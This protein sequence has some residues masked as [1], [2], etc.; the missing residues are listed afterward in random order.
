[1]GDFNSLLNPSL[2]KFHDSPLTIPNYPPSALALLLEELDLW[3]LRHPNVLAYYCHAMGTHSLSRVDYI[4]GNPRAGGMLVDVEY[5]PRA[6]SD[7]SLV[8]AE[9]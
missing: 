7:H 2:D 6:I 8:L 9:L 3:R 1:M 5:L 4:C